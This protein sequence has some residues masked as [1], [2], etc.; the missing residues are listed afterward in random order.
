MVEG[1][2]ICV[3]ECAKLTTMEFCQG[4]VTS[5]DLHVFQW[6][7]EVSSWYVKFVDVQ[8]FAWPEIL[9]L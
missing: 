7:K 4:Y 8:H 9:R 1:I 5:G 6:S 2:A 3:A